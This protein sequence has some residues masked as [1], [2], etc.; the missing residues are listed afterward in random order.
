MN[1]LES[2]LLID[3]S[4]ADNFYHKLVIGRTGVNCE[5]ESITSSHDALKYIYK[6]LITEDESVNPL[7]Q[8]IF[9]DINMPAMNGFE[10]LAK[11]REIPDPYVRKKQIRIFML[12]GS[13]NPDDR[14]LAVEQ[15]GD[16]VSGFRIKPLTQD[17]VSELVK[18]YFPEG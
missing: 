18:E 8:L 11:L 17:V 16:L 10:L 1:K 4:D 14:A 12:T 7:P 6:G 2:I 3:D 15:Y 9:L 5:I 13:M